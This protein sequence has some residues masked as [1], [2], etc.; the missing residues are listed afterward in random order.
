MVRPVTTTASDGA[1]DVG[2]M[3][4]MVLLAALVPAGCVLWFLGAAMENQQLAVR[5]RLSDVYRG[6]FDARKKSLTSFWKEVDGKLDQAQKLDDVTQI[7]KLFITS[8]ICTAV[9]VYDES[10]QVLYPTPLTPPR[11]DSS[12]HSDLW[13]KARQLEYDLKNPLAAETYADIATRCDNI[14]LSARAI[15]AQIRCLVRAG[16]PGEA[17]DVVTGPLSEPK[18]RDALDADGR[19]IVPA[20]RLLALQLGGGKLPPELSDRLIRR[21]VERLWDDEDVIMPSVQRLFLI[22]ALRAIKPEAGS[23]ES[24]GDAAMRAYRLDRAQVYAEGYLDANGQVA[25][26][27]VS[28]TGVG[29]LWAVASS[30]RRIV[31][32]FT[33]AL[34]DVFRNTC[35]TLPTIRGAGLD[36]RYDPT[37]EGDPSAFLS[38]PVG[39][40][41]PGWWIF[42]FLEDPDPFH[43]AAD[44]QRTIYFIIAGVSIALIVVLAGAVA[45]YLGRQMKLTRLKNDFV[46]T[47]SHELKTPLA[48]M[49]IL[50]DTLVDGRVADQAQAHEYLQ[51]I[52]RENLR[53]SRLIDNFLTF[54]RMERSKCAFEFDEIQVA[55]LVNE[56]LESTGERFIGKDRCLEVTVDPDLPP[57]LGDRDA[58]VTVIL[59]LL[60]NAWKYSG[61][62]REIHLKATARGRYVRIKVIDNGI[63]M[64][65]RTARRIFGRFYQADRTLTRSAGGCGLG[66]SIVKFILDAHGA[67][68][69]VVSRP[70]AGST[71]TVIFPAQTSNE[72]DT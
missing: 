48:S 6:Q 27:G 63:G 11:A 8:E 4:I 42:L 2:T 49:R 56:A 51:L 12:A 37:G 14:H 24:D 18:Y 55:D 60:D 17:I 45:R 26:Q 67:S 68:I 53:L 13:D 59:N 36:I 54:S 25:S 23:M 66:L 57:I 10:G 32:L 43:A 29:K 21:L 19:L 28:P 40:H 1:S 64:S 30:D 71:F 35:D 62:D 20:G 22:D 58:L 50:I 7:Y 39:K 5:Q 61:D 33:D 47:V 44:R 70:G 31:V 9:V 16:R 41:M 15:Q 46:A 69:D 72:T 52:A 3:V 34:E 38:E 65:A